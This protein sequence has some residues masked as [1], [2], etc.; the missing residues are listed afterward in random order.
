MTFLQHHLFDEASLGLETIEDVGFGLDRN[1]LQEDH[2]VS[3][4]KQECWLPVF[5]GRNG[6]TP[7]EDRAIKEKALQKAEE[8]VADYRKPTGREEP[9]AKARAVVERARRELGAA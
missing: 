5:Y 6:W 4:F 1:F 2:T 9:L 8:V 7:E 3:R